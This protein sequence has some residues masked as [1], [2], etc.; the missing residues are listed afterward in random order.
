MIN[1]AGDAPPNRTLA[2]DRSI[3]RPASARHRPAGGGPVPSRPAGR[4]TCPTH[5]LDSGGRAPEVDAPPER[6]RTR[7]VP[8]R[9][10][11]YGQEERRGGA[12][13]GDVHLACRHSGGC[14]G[15]RGLCR[16]RSAAAQEGPPRAPRRHR[17]PCAV[18]A[19]RL[20]LPSARDGCRRAGGS[21]PLDRGPR[22]NLLWPKLPVPDTRG[23]FLVTVSEGG[24]PGRPFAVVLLLASRRGVGAIERWLAEGQRTGNFPGLP[25]IPGTSVLD[26]HPLI[27]D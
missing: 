1:G 18:G 4:A 17:G 14:G 19:R 2:G 24:E 5:L 25:T 21:H 3:D 11:C 6:R 8:A 9:E 16:H 12:Q 22:D 13:E 23:S 10:V 7:P 26:V 20:D 15:P 27:H